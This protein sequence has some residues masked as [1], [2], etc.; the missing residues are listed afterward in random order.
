MRHGS[1]HWLAERE[2][3]GGK[4]GVAVD[5]GKL[6]GGKTATGKESVCNLW[7]SLKVKS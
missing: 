7:Q 4:S 5:R 1:G 2:K 3:E 6:K